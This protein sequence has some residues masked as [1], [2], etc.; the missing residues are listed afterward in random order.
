[1]GS[2]KINGFSILPALCVA[3]Q[4]PAGVCVFPQ[5]MTSW[6]FLHNV[7][8]DVGSILPIVLQNCSGRHGGLPKQTRATLAM[9]RYRTS[10]GKMG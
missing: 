8:I 9:R 4:R 10:T 1:M 2:L 7:C 5:K 6:D 3:V